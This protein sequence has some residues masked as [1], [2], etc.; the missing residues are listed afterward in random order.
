MRQGL[1]SKS[2]VRRF[3]GKNDAE[4]AK[5][6][7]AVL[8]AA[9]SSGDDKEFVEPCRMFVAHKNRITSFVLR[10]NQLLTGNKNNVKYYENK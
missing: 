9:A 2:K 8:T 10:C 6:T 3:C 5:L 1:W 7:A 4:C